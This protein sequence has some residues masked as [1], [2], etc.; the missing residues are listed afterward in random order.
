[1]KY[2]SIIN[3]FPYLTPV[4]DKIDQ[5]K[6]MAYLKYNDGG[7]WDCP[8]ELF[9]DNL[10]EQCHLALDQLLPKKVDTEDSAEEYYQR[11]D[12][13]DFILYQHDLIWSVDTYEGEWAG[14]N[15]I[16]QEMWDKIIDKVTSQSPFRS[17]PK[18]SLLRAED[19]GL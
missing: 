18:E 10:W 1:M 3:Q 11:H 15:Q 2:Q 19:L 9:L 8:E 13:L 12:Q 17:L 5:M 7:F 16:E 14:S 6:T 4:F